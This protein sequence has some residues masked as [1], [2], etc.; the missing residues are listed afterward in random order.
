M[1]RRPKP[2][3]V[4]RLRSTRAGLPDLSMY[5]PV[6]LY[7]IPTHKPETLSDARITKVNAN[8]RRK[9]LCFIVSSK[10]AISRKAEKPKLLPL[11]QTPI[12]SVCH[13]VSW[14]L[15]SRDRTTKSRG[16]FH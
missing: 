16:L 1:P 7:F 8:G 5:V 3:C 11:S 14:K 15:K 10:I 13:Q 12:A 6:V 4:R 2:E 9:C